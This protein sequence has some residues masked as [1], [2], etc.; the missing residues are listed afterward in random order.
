[1]SVNAEGRRKPAFSLN[2][3]RWP[4]DDVRADRGRTPVDGLEVPVVAHRVS[5][6]ARHAR[7]ESRPEFAE[8]DPAQQ[9]CVFAIFARGVAGDQHA[10]DA[11]PYAYRQRVRERAPPQRTRRAHLEVGAERKLAV[12]LDEL[13]PDRGA[14]GVAGEDALDDC[15]HDRIDPARVAALACFRRQRTRFDGMAPGNVGMARPRPPRSSV[16]CR[17]NRGSVC[18]S[19]G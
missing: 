11:P 2:P 13:D 4:S 6:A 1:M 5:V 17:C 7:V 16:Q 8:T 15:A 3:G 9:S 14:G 18:A 10:D 19:G 12:L